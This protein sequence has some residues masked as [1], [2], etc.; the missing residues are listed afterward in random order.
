MIYHSYYNLR[1]VHCRI[2][3]RTCYGEPRTGIEGCVQQYHAVHSSR[4]RT[5]THELT[6]R[7]TVRGCHEGKSLKRGC[8][9]IA[10]A[11]RD[12]KRESYVWWRSIKRENY[13]WGK[14]SFV[15]RVCIGLVGSSWSK[16]D[17]EVIYQFS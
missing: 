9:T 1:R 14:L 12:E 15:F 3:S 7:S 4:T 16:S 13:V 17:P 6:R 8:C 10:A 5:H 2:C 11:A